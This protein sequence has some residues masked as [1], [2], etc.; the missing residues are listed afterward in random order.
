MWNVFGRTKASHLQNRPLSTHSNASEDFVY[1]TFESYIS[2]ATQERRGT[3]QINRRPAPRAKAELLTRTLTK[4]AAL[5]REKADAERAL[6]KVMVKEQNRSQRA[7]SLCHTHEHTIQVSVAVM[8]AGS[9]LNVPGWDRQWRMVAEIETV[10]F[11]VVVPDPA[12]K[13][14]WSEKHSD[15]FLLAGRLFD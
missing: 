3:H 13:P 15:A 14:L 9:C 11:G 6:R 2:R 5:Q 8:K 1:D 7:S 4:R 12:Y 10:A